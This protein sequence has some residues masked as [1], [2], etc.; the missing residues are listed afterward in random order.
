MKFLD[1]KG[2]IKAIYCM[3]AVNGEITED[4]LRKFDEL[5]VEICGETFSSFKDSFIQECKEYLEEYWDYEFFT[6]V[7]ME[8]TDQ[9]IEQ[10]E[11]KGRLASRF[12]IWN[13]FAIAYSDGSI[14]DKERRLIGH[15]SRVIGMKRSVFVELEMLM[16]T[17]MDLENELRWLQQSS[18]PYT[19]IKPLVDEIE[20][21]RKNLMKAVKAMIND[22]V[23]EFR[24][25]GKVKEPK[26]KSAVAKMVDETTSK[27]SGVAETATSSVKQAFKNDVAPVAADVGSKLK[28][29]FLSTAKAVGDKSSAILNKN[30]QNKEET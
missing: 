11:E 18:R 20:L 7:V 2:L 17:S 24:V 1:K 29:G 14:D 3:M 12:V 30:Q 8:L 28:S 22:E 10:A 25:Y 13:L 19:E 5:G 16:K 15:I 9:I 27:I 26:E 4:E 6:D 23:Y 21:R